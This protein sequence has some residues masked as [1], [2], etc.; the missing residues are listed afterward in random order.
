MEEVLCNR[1]L[2]WAWGL[3]VDSAEIKR[4]SEENSFFSL[5]FFFSASARGG[6]VY[7]SSDWTLVLLKLLK[8][9]MGLAALQRRESVF[10]SERVWSEPPPGSSVSVIL[11]LMKNTE[12]CLYLISCIS[13]DPQPTPHLQFVR[14][15]RVSSRLQMVRAWRPR[16]PGSFSFYATNVWLPPPLSFQDRAY[17]RFYFSVIGRG[18]V[19]GRTW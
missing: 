14:L 5:Q 18:R 12:S 1:L 19:L 11:F 9:L 2:W 10:V 16:F 8:C 15:S 4:A 17:V 13:L 3:N 6:N 7:G